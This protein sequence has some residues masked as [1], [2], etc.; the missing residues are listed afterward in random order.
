MKISRQALEEVKTALEE[1]KKVVEATNL[2]RTT[3]DTYID[4]PSAFVRW[5]YDDF[6]PG[7]RLK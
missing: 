7:S 4:H 3:K 5:L 1:Y 6:E 2:S